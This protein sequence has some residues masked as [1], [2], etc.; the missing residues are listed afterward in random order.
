MDKQ[1]WRRLGDYVVSRR[2]ELGYRSQG[3]LEEASGISYRTLSRLENGGRVRRS[4]LLTLQR[5]LEW[6]FGSVDMILAGGD[7]RPLSKRRASALQ[8]PDYLEA[9]ASFD[10]LVEKYDFET[11]KYLYTNDIAGGQ[12]VD[13]D[14][15]SNHEDA[16]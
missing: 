15:D 3:A 4:T 12:K 1:D 11:A 13:D 6:E 9:R 5:V 2:T 10:R 16:G 14:D 8:D 7:P